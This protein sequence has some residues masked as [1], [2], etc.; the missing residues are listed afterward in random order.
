MNIRMQKYRVFYNEIRRI[1]PPM[2]F[3]FFFSMFCLIVLS[4]LITIFSKYLE[5]NNAFY[6]EHCVSGSCNTFTIFMVRFFH[7]FITVFYCFYLFLFDASYDRIYVLFYIGILLHWIWFD[8]C[9]WSKIEYDSVRGNQPRKNLDKKES[10]IHPHLDIFF[11]DKTDYFIFFQGVAMSANLAVIVWRFR[12]NTVYIVSKQVFR[13]LK[14][15]SFL[16][17][18]TTQSYLMLKDRVD[19]FSSPLPSNITYCHDHNVV[20]DN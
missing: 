1:P 7:Y 14:I 16:L 15:G 20:H 17:L 8:T 12:Y 2:R 13:W 4:V 11:Q 9:I 3:S 10:I 18:V 6:R 5:E 19:I